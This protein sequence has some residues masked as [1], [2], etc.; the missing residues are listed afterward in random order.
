MFLQVHTLKK[1][2]IQEIKNRYTP[3]EILTHFFFVY[4]YCR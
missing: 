2:Y 3:L 1:K 4:L